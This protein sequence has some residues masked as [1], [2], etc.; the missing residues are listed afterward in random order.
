MFEIV[1]EREKRTASFRCLNHSGDSLNCSTRSCRFRRLVDEGNLVRS[2][3]RS[4]CFD[5]FLSSRNQR[6][7]DLKSF[8]VNE[9]LITSSTQ[10]E[11][12]NDALIKQCDHIVKP[13]P[14]KCLRMFQPVSLCAA[15]QPP[16]HQG[17]AVRRH[18]RQRN[19]EEQKKVAG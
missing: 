1:R 4:E 16:V 9:T 6:K 11:T 12:R 19:G 13:K 7:A 3:I 2:E 14:M 15:L 8:C 18:S 17:A 5:R 10:A